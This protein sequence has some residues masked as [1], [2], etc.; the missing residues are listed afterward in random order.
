MGLIP[1]S[2]RSLGGGHGRPP[3]SSILEWRIPQTEEP[4]GLQPMKLESQT[5]LLID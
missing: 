4:G 3:Y 2:G 1:G 5:R